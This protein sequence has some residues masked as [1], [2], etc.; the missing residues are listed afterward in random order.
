MTTEAAVLSNVPYHRQA[1]ARPLVGGSRRVGS[2]LILRLLTSGAALIVLLM[3]GSLV[4]VLAY[5]AMPSVRTFGLKFLVSSEWRPNELQ[6]PK[7]DAN[8]D[9][10][11]EDGETVMET[12]PPAFG[13][14]PV[15][16]GTAVSSRSRY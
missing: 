16:Y 7:H 10:I 2:D 9:P 15:I 6:V 14:L 11:I 4:A 1:P 13:A 5:A 8:G 12:I 3:L